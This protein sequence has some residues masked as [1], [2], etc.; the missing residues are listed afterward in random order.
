[1]L[2]LWKPADREVNNRTPY[3]GFAMVTM[4]LSEFE[5]QVLGRELKHKTVN[6]IQGRTNTNTHTQKR[7]F[8]ICTSHWILGNWIMT[9][10]F[11]FLVS[12]DVI[13]TLIPMA[14]ENNISIDEMNRKINV[15]D[16]E[17]R[18][19][20]YEYYRSLHRDPI[21]FDRNVPVSKE[22]AT[23]IFYPENT[24]KRFLRN[25]GKFILNH[26]TWQPHTK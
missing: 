15:R 1:M 20:V 6:T 12:T 16:L 8:I 24:G 3:R 2:L 18:W 25:G 19:W 5:K 26:T 22:S 17:Y 10:L 11:N 4:A 7:R 14:G 9:L 21:Y 23:S 13:I